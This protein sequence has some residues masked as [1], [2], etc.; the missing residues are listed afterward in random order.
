MASTPRNDADRNYDAPQSPRSIWLIISVILHVLL[1]A[2]IASIPAR[3]YIE[4]KLREREIVLSEEEAQRLQE[5]IEQANVKELQQKVDDLQMIQQDV[6]QRRDQRFEQLDQFQQQ[7]QK[8]LAERLQEAMDKVL[9]SQEKIADLETQSMKE[10]EKV[11]KAVQQVAR[12]ADRKTVEKMV[13]QSKPI[14]EQVD[15]AREPQQDAIK[16][17]EKTTALMENADRLMDFVEDE[18]LQEEWEEAR[19]M[20]TEARQVLQTARNNLSDR[21]NQVERATNDYEKNQERWDNF[22]KMMSQNPPEKL[23]NS[24]KRTQRDVDTAKKRL[25]DEPTHKAEIEQAVV[26]QREAMKKLQSVAGKAV[27]KAKEQARQQQSERVKPT[28]PVADAPTQQME[29]AELYEQ[30]QVLEKNVGEI[31]REAR[32]AELSMLTEQP[33]ERSMQNTQAPVSDRQPIDTE[34]LTRKSKNAADIDAYKEVLKEANTQ[35]GSMLAAAM[36]MQQALAAADATSLSETGLAT[37]ASTG[38]GMG[39]MQARRAMLQKLNA[40]ASEVT[41]SVSDVSVAMRQAMAAGGMEG[42]HLDG[43]VEGFAGQ[44]SGGSLESSAPD[45]PK[46]NFKGY[47]GRRIS[48][49]GTP[50]EW[51]YISGWYTIGPFP[52]EDRKNIETVFPPES[53]IDLDATYPGKGGK[54]VAW[55]WM[56]SPIVRVAPVDEQPYAIYY[57]YTELWLDQPRD[58]WIAIGSDDRSD[59]WVNGM[60]VWKSSNE[61]KNWQMNEGMRKVHFKAGRNKILVRLENGWHACHFSVLVH[62]RQTRNSG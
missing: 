3:D 23:N 1:L 5:S 24:Q 29:P 37:N 51:F 31:Y 10:V 12:N 46:L 2:W 21:A 32:A 58:L 6:T 57:A 45:N 18:S 48:P 62:T 43:A 26:A 47:A 49:D 60:P 9:E 59:M 13:E 50:A 20:Q 16:E 33:M 52:N 34:A 28:E 4:R 54:P 56:N 53:I 42:E 15:K 14:P 61:L 38:T 30:A 27:S 11:E 22:E 40:A 44:D 8:D 39:Q 7:M 55:T 41:G 35:V 17:N 25:T 19:Q 36:S